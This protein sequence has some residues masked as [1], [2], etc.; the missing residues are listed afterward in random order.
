MRLVKVFCCLICINAH[1]SSFNIVTTGDSNTTGFSPN[2][3]ANTMM[4]E[5]IAGKAMSIASG[6]ANSSIYVGEIVDPAYQPAPVAHN[7][8]IDSLFGPVYGFGEPWTYGSVIE[9]NPDPD[10]VTVMLGTNDAILAT[11]DISVWDRYKV[12]MTES[13]NYLTTTT[14]P[15][16]KHP[17]IFVITPIPILAQQYSAADVFLTSTIIPWLKSQVTGLK[18]NGYRI[19]LIDA[20]ENIKQQPNWEAWY[21]DGVHMYAG[22]NEGYQ[23]LA[24]EVIKSILD[25][26]QGDANLDGSVDSNDYFIWANNYQ[27]SHIGNY[28]QGDFNHNGLLDSGDYEIWADRYGIGASSYPN[29]TTPVPIPPSIFGF[30]SALLIIGRILVVRKKSF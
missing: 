4:A 10:A 14:T 6:G 27:I 5:G 30:I 16:G 9:Q 21:N 15:G 29:L 2:L 1:A 3:L 17:D 7:Q 20:N 22:N 12:N 19:H 11:S 13:F 25:A 28:S 8:A 23:W 26:H 24:R 18:N